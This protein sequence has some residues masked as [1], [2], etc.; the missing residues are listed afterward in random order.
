[1]LIGVVETLGSTTYGASREGTSVT[2]EEIYSNLP[3]EP[4]EAFLILEAHF[5]QICENQLSFEHPTDS[6][7]VIR[8]RYLSRVLAAIHELGLEAKAFSK[9]IPAVQ[10]LDQYTYANVITEGDHYRTALQIRRARRIQGF[11]VRFDAATK[12]KIRHHLTQ[13]RSI[14]DKLEIDQEKKDALYSRITA[15]EQEVDRERTRLEAYG[16]LVIEVAGVLGDAAEK[17]EPLRRWLDS[18]GK[19]IWGAQ[20]EEEVRRLPSPGERKRIEPPSTGALANGPDG[21][22]DEIP[23]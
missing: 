23:F 13:V 3:D 11:S 1:M 5:R 4:E 2:D 20:K 12:Q 17:L 22:E 18:I 21:L 8:L 16:A 10:D 14:V 7:D 6:S 15:L 9:K 19:L